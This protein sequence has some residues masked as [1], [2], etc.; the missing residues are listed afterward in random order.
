MHNYKI[1]TMAVAIGTTALLFPS[2]TRHDAP[3]KPQDNKFQVTDSLLGSLLVDTVQQASAVSQITLTGTIEPDENKIAKI[4]PLVSG[5]T[6]NVNVLLGDVVSKGQTLASM[7]SVE[8]AGFSKDLISAEA[9]LRDTKRTLEATQ[10]LYQSGLASG[11]DLEQAKSDYKKALAENS[12]ASS[13]MS[14][15]KSDKHGYL[16][17][18]PI[19][20]YIVEKNVTSNMQVR[21][22]NTENLFTIADLSSVYIIVNIYE[23]D[24]TSVQTGYPVKITTLAY[25]GKVFTG[26]IDKVYN[27]IDRDNKLMRA[28]VKISNPGNLLKPQMFANVVVQAKSGENLPVINTRSIVLDNDRNYVVVKDGKAQ[29][30]IQPITV[31]KRVEDRAYISEGLKP[32]DQI[33]ASR[34]LFLYESL[35]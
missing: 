32:G 27:M 19:S 22:D 28:R 30:R 26:K 23:S 13:V 24:I 4:Y 17:K 1:L 5:V 34:Q 8:V 15:N 31:S 11:K 18:A 21:A 35:K 3:L 6:E 20:G 9:D 12:R 10:D 16:I 2:C 33:I 7:H 29:V 25:P 14:I